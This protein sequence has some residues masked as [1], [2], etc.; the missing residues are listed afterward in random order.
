MTGRDELCAHLS[1]VVEK[2]A[3]FNFSVTQDIGVRRAARTVLLEEMLEY[4]IPVL[5]SKICT[6]KRDAQTVCHGLSV[7]EIL[8]RGTVFCAVVLLPVL[9][10]EAF[11]SI[12]LLEQQHSGHRRVHTAGHADN[13][14]STAP[15]WLTHWLI[16]P[17]QHDFAGKHEGSDV[18]GQRPVIVRTLGGTRRALCHRFAKGQPPLESGEE[19]ENRQRRSSFEPDDY[20]PR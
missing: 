18:P 11:D 5:G 1:G 16:D 10:K 6:V 13:D 3:K 17:I 8:F 9:H 14:G 12:S 4:V 15:C 19:W 2:R 7:S 20:D